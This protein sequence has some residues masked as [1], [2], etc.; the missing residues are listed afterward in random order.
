MVFLSVS[1]EMRTRRDK[2]RSR[3]DLVSKSRR[4]SRSGLL[5]I[6][7]INIE[8]HHI[9]IK[10]IENSRQDLIEISTKYFIISPT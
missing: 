2:S 1:V 8:I 3:L 9:K 7:E 4:D 5:I 10:I 6:F